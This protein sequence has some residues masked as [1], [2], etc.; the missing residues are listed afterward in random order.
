MA[1]RETKFVVEIAFKSLNEIDELVRI[2]DLYKLPSVGRYQV[3]II[4]NTVKQ[5]KYELESL[6]LP[7]TI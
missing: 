2:L 3:D 6:T 4:N 5:L 1:H 7:D